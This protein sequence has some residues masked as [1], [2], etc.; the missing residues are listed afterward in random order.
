M[1][2]V[3]C[4]RS[5]EWSNVWSC[6]SVPR[7]VTP[8]TWGHATARPSNGASVRLHE[9]RLVEKG[10]FPNNV[11]SLVL[12]TVRTTWMGLL[13][14]LDDDSVTPLPAG[15]DRFVARCPS[16][17]LD[18]DCV[19]SQQARECPDMMLCGLRGLW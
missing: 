4:V 1:L 9:G 3:T 11:G 10:E 7:P 12:A 6:R 18:G 13:D 2:Q 5:A 14:G 8:E 15:N 19:Q 16:H 17:G